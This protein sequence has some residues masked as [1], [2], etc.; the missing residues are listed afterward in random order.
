MDNDLIKHFRWLL[1]ITYANACGFT[2]EEE[3][4]NKRILEILKNIKG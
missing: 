3:L 2:K 4:K 1:F